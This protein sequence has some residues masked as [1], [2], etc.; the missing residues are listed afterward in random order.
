[1]IHWQWF[2]SEKPGEKAYIARWAADIIWP[3]K[4]EDI[5]YFGEQVTLGVFRD[6]TLIGAAIYHNWNP[7]FGV[8]EISGAATDSRW[9]TRSVLREMY[10]YPFEQLGCQMVV[11]RTPATNERLLGILARLDFDFIEIPR[12]RG[13]NE[14][15]TVCTLTDDAYKAGKFFREVHNGVAQVSDAA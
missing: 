14:A 6:S 13:R 15:E 4:E 10:R 5:Q 12:L 7:Q 2:G 1:M 11:Q 3:N 8:I 9:L